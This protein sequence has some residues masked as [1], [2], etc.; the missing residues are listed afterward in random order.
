M[1]VFRGVLTAN[2]KYVVVLNMSQSHLVAKAGDWRVSCYNNVSQQDL[3]FGACFS[4]LNAT[5]PQKT[6][7]STSAAA[8]RRYKAS[9]ALTLKRSVLGK[10][11]E[12]QWI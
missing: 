2:L 3:R 1:E 10:R 12:W 11:V 4:W 7:S 9:K 8:A 6:S 5:L